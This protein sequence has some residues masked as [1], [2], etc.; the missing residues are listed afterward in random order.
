MVRGLTSR[1]DLSELNKGGESLWEGSAD[2]VS[3]LSN[4]G[5]KGSPCCR[6]N[7]GRERRQTDDRREVI[8]LLY[9]ILMQPKIQISELTALNVQMNIG[10]CIG[11]TENMENHH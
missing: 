11:N 3:A 2:S 7:T 9:K 8:S 4:E 6:V 1:S 10:N 5:G